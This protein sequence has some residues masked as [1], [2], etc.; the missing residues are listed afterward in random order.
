MSTVSPY[1]TTAELADELR[2]STWLVKKL[3]REKGIG[4]RLPG[5]AG[6]RFTSGDV[7]SL[8]TILAPAPPVERRRRRRSA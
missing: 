8:R 4:L 7:E 2:C 3:A 6:W 5:K 1:M